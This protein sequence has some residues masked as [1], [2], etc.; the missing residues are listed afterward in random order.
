[1][2][3]LESAENSYITL[4]SQVS[5]ATHSV[6]LWKWYL[7]QYGSELRQQQFRELFEGL[8]T[9]YGVEIAH[10]MMSA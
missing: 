7:E 4:A 8:N 10:E 5:T 2:K 9:L 6:N 1:M 3:F